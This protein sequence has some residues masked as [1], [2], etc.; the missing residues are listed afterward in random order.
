[1]KSISGSGESRWLFRRAL[2]YGLAI[3]LLGVLQCAF[4]SRLK[5]FGATPDLMLGAVCAIA[6]LDSKY[7]AAVCAVGAGYFIDAIGATTP[8]F[9]AVFYLVVVVTVATLAEK[10]INKL[11]SF[12]LLLL[13][14]IALRAV[15]TFLCVCLTY[16]KLAPL[17]CLWTLILPEAICTLICCIP[18]FYLIKLCT[19]P[20]SSRSKFSF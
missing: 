4:F 13:P 17:S 14:A 2:I 12:M 11:P 15:Y 6:L 3:F 5:L 8:S 9:S 19:I 16:G 18:V 1:M 20:I 10:L 7:A